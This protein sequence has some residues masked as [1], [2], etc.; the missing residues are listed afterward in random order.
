M[1]IGYKTNAVSG[2]IKALEPGT[3]SK[4]AHKWMDSL[5]NPSVWVPNASK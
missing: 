3:K 2:V 4:V 5:H 1:K